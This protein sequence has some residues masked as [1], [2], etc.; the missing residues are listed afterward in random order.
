MAKEKNKKAAEVE[1]QVEEEVETTEEELEGSE[2]SEDN[3]DEG[4][5]DSNLPEYMRVGRDSIEE[6]SDETKVQ[7]LEDLTK[8]MFGYA[9]DFMNQ[10]DA[11]GARN[12][13]IGSGRARKAAVMFRK[14]V[15]AYR[16]LSIHVA[17]LKRAEKAE[18]K[19]KKTTEVAEAKAVAPKKEKVVEKVVEK[20]AKK[21]PK[22]PA[23][24]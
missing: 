15:T 17:R 11:F 2:D 20:V 24:K 1:E 5:D 12:I 8:A 16:L 7:Y 21:A 3:E 14:C 6:L 22:K 19:S 9:A 23:K 4:V 10:A 13:L 18:A